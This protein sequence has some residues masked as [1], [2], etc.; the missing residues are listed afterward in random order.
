MPILGMTM[1]PQPAPAQFCD[2]RQRIE[3]AP[4][5]SQW[6]RTRM[7]PNASQSISPSPTTIAVCGPCTTGT[8]VRRGGTIGAVSGINA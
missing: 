5:R 4:D 1:P 7:R 8:A 2:T 6:N 3:C